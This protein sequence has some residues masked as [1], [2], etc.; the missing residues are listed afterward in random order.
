MVKDLPANARDVDSVPGL[1]IS[2]VKETVTRA[3]QPAA[4]FLPGN[5][6][7]RAV[8]RVAVHRVAKDATEQLNNNNI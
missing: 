4:V 3:K 1:E 6:M 5:P 2:T 7:N 8:W